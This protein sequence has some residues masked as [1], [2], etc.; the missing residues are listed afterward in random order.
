[1]SS[2]HDRLS[3]AELL[4]IDVDKGIQVDSVTSTL[5]QTNQDGTQSSTA[6]S[7]PKRSSDK[8]TPEILL[9]GRGLPKL[10][11]TFK[12]FKFTKR[13][14]KGKASKHNGVYKKVQYCDDHHYD[15]LTRIIQIYQ[16]WGHSISP[17]LMFDRFIGNL[18]RGIQKSD[19]KYWIREQIREEIRG[20]VDRILQKEATEMERARAERA[21]REHVENNKDSLTN[22]EPDGVAGEVDVEEER[23]Q[24]WAALFGGQSQATDKDVNENDGPNNDNEDDGGYNVQGEAPIFSTF[25]RTSSQPIHSD[26]GSEHHTSE[27]ED[28]PEDVMDGA[29]RDTF[30]ALDGLD[31]DEDGLAALLE[32]ESNNEARDSQMFSQY[33]AHE[34]QERTLSKSLSPTTVGT[35]TTETETTTQTTT[36]TTTTLSTGAS[37]GPSRPMTPKEEGFS[38]VDEDELLQL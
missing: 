37:E 9:S 31:E 23:E 8:L 35:L 21:A 4:G 10:I 5:F 6:K 34:P 15:N 29:A 12:R 24:D 13:S 30:D 11:D 14:A 26:L 32:A 18:D 36:Q 25:L 20:K 7:K 22:D 28:I 16:N 3:R 33:I 17:H 19:V 38:D 27:M 1:M 2:S